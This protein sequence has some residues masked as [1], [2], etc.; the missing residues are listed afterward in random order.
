MAEAAAYDVVAMGRVGVDIY[1]LQHGVGLEKVRTF[2]EKAERQYLADRDY[3]GLELAVL[4]H[5]MGLK[6]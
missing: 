6:A 1:P 2:D 4:E 5:L 3:E